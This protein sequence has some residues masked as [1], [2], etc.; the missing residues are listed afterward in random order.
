MSVV[1]ARERLGRLG[2]DQPSLI[3]FPYGDELITFERA[4]RS[5]S[6]SKVQIKVYPDCK[7]LVL[8]PYS[9]TEEEVLLAVKKRGRWIYNKLRDFREQLSNATPRQ[10][11]SGESHY[12][13]GKR[14]MLKVLEALGEKEKVKLS[15]GKLEVSVQQKNPDKVR[16]LLN[17]WYKSR[18]VDVFNR[19][20]EVLLSQTL[21]VVERPPLRIQT[22]QTQW[23]SCSA[24]GRLTLNPYLVKAPRECVDYVILHELCHIAEHNH[25]ERFYRLLRQVMPDWEAVKTRLDEMACKL[26]T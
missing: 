13:L 14:Q 8:A 16:D 25:S 1:I 19:R 18:A 3:S 26:I 6:S 24:N 22:M 10:Y 4:I 11:V 2:Q 23:G 17:Q 9:A 20:L 21:W 5:G 15:R 7:V 12:Y